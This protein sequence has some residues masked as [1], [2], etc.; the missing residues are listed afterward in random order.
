M[1]GLRSTNQV[2]GIFSG[3]RNVAISLR[4]CWLFASL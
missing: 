1:F 4:T 2:C 3:Q